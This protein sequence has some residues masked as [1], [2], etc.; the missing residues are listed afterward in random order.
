[1]GC[2][3]SNI[4]IDSNIETLLVSS[5]INCTIFVAAV[6]KICTIEKCENVNLCIAAN[7]V[8]I[9]NCIDSTVY[10][11]NPTLSPIVYGDTRSLKLGPH[12]ASYPS[13]PDHL[14]R[15]LIKFE[16]SLGEKEK[17]SEW[18][19]EQVACL[20]KPIMM[21]QGD[22]KQKEDTKTQYSI[23]QPVDFNRIVLPNFMQEAPNMNNSLLPR[24]TLELCPREY[25]DMIN[26]RI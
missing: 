22:K 2:E 3:E 15:A 16:V 20:S 23:M 13:L 4:Y 5:C 6:S 12:N 8:R 24:T 17:H 18:F 10:S 7:E 11:Y 21:A 26:S 19:D 25:L 1:M 9:G 14:K